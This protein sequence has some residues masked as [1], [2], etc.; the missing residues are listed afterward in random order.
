MNYSGGSMN[1]SGGGKNYSGGSMNYSGGSIKCI[2]GTLPPPGYDKPPP[3][4][5]FVR[6]DWNERYCETPTNQSNL[7]KE[8]CE[9]LHPES[10]RKTESHI[11][12]TTNLERDGD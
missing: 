1:Y 8:N 6:D 9:Y 5:R 11:Y 10:T 12:N 4:K 2:E 3:P 7:Q